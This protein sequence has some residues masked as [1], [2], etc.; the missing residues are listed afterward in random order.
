VIAAP[1]KRKASPS[2]GEEERRSTHAGPASSTTSASA[3]GANLLTDPS[4]RASRPAGLMDLPTELLQQIARHVGA[5][6]G[7]PRAPLARDPQSLARLAAVNKRLWAA[8]SHP[9]VGLG[10]ARFASVHAASP[11]HGSEGFESEDGYLLPAAAYQPTGEGFHLHP[12]SRALWE[13]GAEGNAFSAVAHLPTGRISLY[14]L[15]VDPDYPT[16]AWPGQGTFQ[17][18]PVVPIQHMDDPRAAD[19]A[20]VSH[21]VLAKTLLGGRKRHHVGFTVHIRNGQPHF[22][23]SSRSLN[24]KKFKSRWKV[25]TEGGGH[26]TKRVAEHIAAGFWRDLYAPPG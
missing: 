14:P 13:A 7:G 4:I 19:P 3:G 25:G 1:P 12:D 6:E 10:A 18:Q 22:V 21:E 26:P 24:K 20:S 17:G 2:G 8:A 11:N 5:A 9:S 16:T 23:W 15:A